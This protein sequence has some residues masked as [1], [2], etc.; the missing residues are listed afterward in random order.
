M[1]LDQNPGV[2]ALAGNVAFCELTVLEIG[3]QHA[4]HPGLDVV[5]LTQTRS[6][7]N[8]HKECRVPNLHAG[9]LNPYALSI[10]VSE[11]DE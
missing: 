8:T 5:A 6:E 3:L 11:V 10:D 9:H 7:S 1:I 2:V 4:V